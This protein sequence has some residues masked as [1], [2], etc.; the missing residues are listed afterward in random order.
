MSGE[1][2]RIPSLD[3]LRGI[4]ILL[5][6]PHNSDLYPGVKNWAFPFA[7]LTHAGWTG[8]QLFFVLSGFL[9]TGALVDS[10]GSDNYYRAFFARRVLRIFP[11]YFLVLVVFLLILPRMV[12]LDPAIMA[13]YSQQKWL[14]VFLSNWT[15]PF[16]GAVT[17]FPHFWSL[18]VE[19]QFYLIWPFVIAIMPPRYML[20]LT[21]AVTLVAIATRLT[22]H[23]M[24]YGAEVIYMFTTTR[25]DALAIGAATALLARRAG[26]LD[27]LRQHQ[28]RGI[29]LVL[30]LALA[31]AAI[32]HAFGTDNLGTISIGY[33]LIALSAALLLL[34]LRAGVG[35]NTWL[36]RVFSNPLLRSCGRYSYAMYVFHML[37]IQL[38]GSYLSGL[39]LPAGSFRPML[40]SLTII[41]LSYGLGWLSYRLYE[42][43][44]LSLKRYFV[45]QCDGI[46]HGI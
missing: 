11:L 25:M 27:T 2:R 1:P 23:A 33:T 46:H 7:V 16:H 38:L 14:W 34:T 20:G 13:T 17:W 44:F 12:R 39:L 31:S 19:E 18:A 26:I 22:L 21:A 42:R 45:P 4:A 41:L 30:V 43:H 10:R 9:I 29:V 40:Y 36:E 5:V 3:G 15:Q 28:D 24:G 37:L 6:I 35:T 8:V 32:S